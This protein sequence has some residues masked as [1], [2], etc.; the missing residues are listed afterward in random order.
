VSV[1]KLTG[2]ILGA[3]FARLIDLPANR[4]AALLFVCFEDYPIALLRVVIGKYYIEATFP[5][6]DL[7]M[8]LEGFSERWLVPMVNEFHNDNRAELT[9]VESHENLPVSGV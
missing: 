2:A 6:Q 9:R 7:E 3:E 4:V 5:P 1:Y 8:S